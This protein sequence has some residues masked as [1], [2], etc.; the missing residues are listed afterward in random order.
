MEYTYNSSGL[1]TKTED[2]SNNTI[3]T[4]EYDPYGNVT[5]IACASETDNGTAL[6]VTDYTYDIT[7]NLLTAQ[8]ES[9]VSSFIYDAAGRQVRSETDGAVS[10]TLYD[11]C[12][13]VKQ[14]IDSD[15]Y[16]PAKDGSRQRTRIPT[17]RQGTPMY[18]RK[19][20]AS[21]RRPQST[22][23]KPNT[24][25]RMSVIC[26]KSILIY[27]ITIIWMTAV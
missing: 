23:L 26:I 4:Y 20:A 15:V 21:R 9:S 16:D 18:T 25:T 27:T 10:R 24:L 2:K 17:P 5:K 3:T 22:A 6:S 1:L 11:S 12:G 19:T 13:R 7:G 8:N 14:Q